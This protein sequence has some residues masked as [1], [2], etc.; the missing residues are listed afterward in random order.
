MV[1]EGF[2]HKEIYEDLI[3]DTDMD[4]LIETLVA[5]ICKGAA[6][7]FLKKPERRS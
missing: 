6:M 7:P 2:L 4:R 3:V 5:K 1:N